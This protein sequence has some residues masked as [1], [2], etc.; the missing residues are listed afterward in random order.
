[1]LGSGEKVGKIEKI[2]KVGEINGQGNRNTAHPCDDYADRQVLF[3][4]GA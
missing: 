4:P 3:R 2:M 1:M